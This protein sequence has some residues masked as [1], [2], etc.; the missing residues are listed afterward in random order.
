MLEKPDY[1]FVWCPCLRRWVAK[2]RRRQAITI[3]W[4]SILVK[5]APP[6]PLSHLLSAMAACLG[7]E[8]ALNRSCSRLSDSPSLEA[9]SSFACRGIFWTQ[10]V[11]LLSLSGILILCDDEMLYWPYEA[12]W[13]QNSVSQRQAIREWPEFQGIFQVSLS[14]PTA[15]RVF[16]HSSFFG[17]FF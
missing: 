2:R 4:C 1:P 11:S 15:L 13:K 16:R 9:L 7:C 10:A 5:P 6:L 8:D 17:I 12:K 3:C 14:D